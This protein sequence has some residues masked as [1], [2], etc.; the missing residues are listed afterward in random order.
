MLTPAFQDIIPET[1]WMYP[2]APTSKPLNPAFDKLVK[3][4]QALGFSAA[5][6]AANRKAWVGE[7][8]KAMSQ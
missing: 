3:P 4:V 8:L 2:A 6:V 1:N 7:W 5:E